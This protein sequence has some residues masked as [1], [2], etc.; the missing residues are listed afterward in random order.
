MF[1]WGSGKGNLIDAPH[2]S[3]IGVNELK[4]VGAGDQIVVGKGEGLGCGVVV[5]CGIEVIDELAVE[6]HLDLSGAIDIESG[7][8]EVEI[9]RGVRDVKG[10]GDG[11]IG[12]LETIPGVAVF[13]AGGT[14]DVEDFIEG[15]ACCF[16]GDLIDSPGVSRIANDELERVVTCN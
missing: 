12:I 9:F 15:G 10:E 6:E 5:A 2:P 8:V 3:R 1:L 13:G 16:K 4:G 11:A 7:E 14:T